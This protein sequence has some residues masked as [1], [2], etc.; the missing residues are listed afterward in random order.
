MSYQ[1]NKRQRAWLDTSTSDDRA[2]F[3][4]K[5]PAHVP[6]LIN[7]TTMEP[8]YRPAVRGIIIEGGEIDVFPTYQEALTSAE[9]F[10]EKRRAEA[11]KLPL[12]DERALGI[13]DTY[14]SLGERIRDA[15]VS[16]EWAIPL[17]CLHDADLLP[18]HLKDFLE[19][20]GESDLKRLE[21]HLPK[22]VAAY[23][24][25]DEEDEVRDALIE[26]VRW[27]GSDGVILQASQPTY[28]NLGSGTMSASY[29]VQS[30]AA[31]YG[32]SFEDACEQAIT[33][34]ATQIEEARTIPPKP[35]KRRAA[36]A[37][38]G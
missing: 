14:R 20:I 12:L 26:D 34:G 15:S 24:A 22:M 25:E 10:L 7:T 3:M 18:D 27:N 4:A 17:F 30:L 8:V 9:A 28:E 16:I 1:L 5:G 33:W 32:N 21:P 38:H 23:H 31:F 19:Y 2:V 6:S 35:K 11:A 29:G 13:D 36:E 37:A